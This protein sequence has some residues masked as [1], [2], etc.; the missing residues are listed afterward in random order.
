MFYLKKYYIKKNDK[1][2]FK[3]PKIHQNATKTVQLTPKFKI[4]IFSNNSENSLKR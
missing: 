4:V 3:H 2:I 1:E